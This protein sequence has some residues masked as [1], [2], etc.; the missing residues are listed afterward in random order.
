[1]P[2]LQNTSELVNLS[3]WR[4]KTGIDAC[5]KEKGL[6]MDTATTFFAL[7][8]IGFILLFPWPFPN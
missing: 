2:S 1:M 7:I 5:G 3:E 6:N 4:T 8:T